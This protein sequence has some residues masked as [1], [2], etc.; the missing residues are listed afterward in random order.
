MKIRDYR[1][2]GY[3]GNALIVAFVVA[4]LN[5]TNAVAQ[6][7]ADADS[8]E[9][10]KVSIWSEGTRM[11]G[12]LYYPKTMKAEDRL[13]AIVLSHGWGGTK[14]GL[15]DYA[16][17]FAMEGYIALA[18][19]YR[20]WGESDGRLVV[21]GDMPKADADGNVQVNAQVI[22]TVVDPFDQVTDIRHAVD[23]ITG[24]PNVDTSRIGYWGSSYS[25]GHAVWV[26]VNEP[27]VSCVVGQVA[28]AD[29]LDLSRTS[30]KGTDI[31]KLGHERAIARARG[32]VEPVPQGTDKAPNLRGWAILEKVIAYRPV[33][34][35]GKIT[36]PIFMIDAENEE[37]F[38]RHLAGELAVTRAKANGAPAKYHVVKG[39]THYGIY[40]GEPKREALDLAV[41]WYGEHLK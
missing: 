12:D 5:V 6:R 36:I 20:G 1:L 32:E 25:G 15:R 8:V 7:S 41:E 28:A 21:N 33:E 38:D 13:P 16:T 35:A 30:W 29:S 14:A 18:F 31:E 3:T 11:A 27:R 37:L 24:E 17:R 40:S 39:I 22:R 2:L 26:A 19:D 34:D 9:M 23:F 10:R 4:M